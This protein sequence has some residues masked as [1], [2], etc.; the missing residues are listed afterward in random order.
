MKRIARVL[1]AMLVLICFC[2]PV[3][4]V[5]ATDTVPYVCDTVGLLTDEEWLSLEQ[6]AEDISE[7]YQCAVY[8]ITVDDYTDYGNGSIY[9]VA[10]ELYR[11]NDLGWGD[12][13]S[14]VMLLLSM[15]QRDYTLI[16][17][18]YGNTAFTDFGKEHL[19]DQF[20][21]DFGHNDWASG[22]KDYLDTC[23]E[24]LKLA[25]DGT[26]YDRGSQIASWQVLV[27]SLLL[28]FP[29]AWLIC[30]IWKTSAQ[31]EVFV[32]GEARDYLNTGSLHFTRREDRFTHATTSR[33]KIEKSTQG[34]RGTTVDRDGF[35]G[36]SG[37]F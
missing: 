26:P 32:N 9:A 18:G 13:A 37:K 19:A 2:L 30:W 12:E 11:A 21:D 35:S 20:L 16:A 15:A 28:G 6:Q 10:K 33:R 7:Q 36:K 14:G 17:Y 29:I 5:K 3:C 25:Q 1:F 23:G 31:K 34:S 4:T 8:F 22:C 27:V 24:L